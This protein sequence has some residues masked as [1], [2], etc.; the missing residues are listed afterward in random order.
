[1]LKSPHIPF[2]QK[3]PAL[4][5]AVMGKMR[6]ALLGGS[7][8]SADGRLLG[9]ALF[10]SSEAGV[11][12]AFLFSGDT[13]AK[14]SSV[15]L[16]NSLA[17]KQAFPLVYSAAD[18]GYHA[19]NP[20]TWSGCFFFA[21][22]V[23][24]T[25]GYGTWAP[26]TVGGK[27]FTIVYALFAVG[28]FGLITSAIG[29]NVIEGVMQLLREVRYACSEPPS[30]VEFGIQDRA[31]AGM[32]FVVFVIS[33]H[34]VFCAS[35]VKYF[36]FLAAGETT[37][38]SLLA[39]FFWFSPV[40]S[41]NSIYFWVV[42]VTS[43]GLG[44]FADWPL[45]N[46]GEALMCLGTLIVP[47]GVLAGVYDAVA[48]GFFLWWNRKANDEKGVETKSDVDEDVLTSSHADVAPAA[49]EEGGTRSSR[50]RPE[51]FNWIEYHNNGRRPVDETD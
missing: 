14:M 24:S 5:N 27:L 15:L 6:G 1:M 34:I 23:A 19:D 26:A 11:V 45:T 2:A 18:N 30:R 36:G 41:L 50:V 37:D 3:D 28:I 12:D 39:E 7:L 10:N 47:M 21:L 40:A 44:D 13:T 22:T 25:V 35:P 31:R 20:W 16:V 43:V 46:G 17:K 32:F 29:A 48:E 38:V 49:D 9:N 42:T 51:G 8:L 4:Y 33:V